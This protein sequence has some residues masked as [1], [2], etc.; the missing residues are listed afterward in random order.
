MKKRELPSGIPAIDAV[1]R[2]HRRVVSG[3]LGDTHINI[4][5]R[6]N[7][8]LLM[9][10]LNRHLAAYGIS[11]VSY[12]TMVML[13]STPHNLANPS[14]LCRATGETRGNMTRICDELVDKGLMQRVPN[15]EDRRRVDLSL[16]DAGVAVLHEV[17]PKLRKEMAAVYRCFT[18]DEKATFAGLLAKLNQSYEAHL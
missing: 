8:G 5:I 10:W 9:D 17:I 3:S 16:T 6:L 14:E 2:A 4:L 15:E 13:H 1:T 11:N 12:F 7:H 18:D